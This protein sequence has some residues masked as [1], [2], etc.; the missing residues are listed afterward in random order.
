MGNRLQ[1]KVA[2]ITGA[3]SGFGKA[4]ATRFAKE[5]AKVVAVDVTERIFDTVKEIE[6]EVLPL[7]VDVTSPEQVNAMYEKCVQE[8]GRVDI[9]CNNA[10]V[11]THQ[12][13]MHEYPTWR[14]G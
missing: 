8:F 1:D 3:A 2:V 5:G 10:G 6:G 7:I 14:M 9:L 11:N 13:P 12:G 4:M